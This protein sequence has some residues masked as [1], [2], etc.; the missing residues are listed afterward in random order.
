MDCFS[1]NRRYSRHLFFY[2]LLINPIE[3]RNAFRFGKNENQLKMTFVF[4]IIAVVLTTSFTI[5]S[6]IQSVTM[7]LDIIFLSSTVYSL[8]MTIET[9]SNLFILSSK[10]F[11][12]LPDNVKAHKTFDINSLTDLIPILNTNDL[13]NF[14]SLTLFLFFIF[15]LQKQINRI[16]KEGA[17]EESSIS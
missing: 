8:I 4:M 14:L 15:L 17:W 12:E 9:G 3:I 7:N 10:F 5:Y 1:A 2:W 16:W 13:L 11:K 6:I